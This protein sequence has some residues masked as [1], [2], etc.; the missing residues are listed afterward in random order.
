MDKFISL[1]DFIDFAR[2]NRKYPDSTANNLKSA[3]KI[4]QKELNAEELKSIDMVQESIEEIFRSLVI[5]N[6]EKSIISLNS[7]KARLLKVIKDYRKYGKEPGKMQN[8]ST[9][10]KKSTGVLIKEDKTDKKKISLSNFINDSVENLHKI[11]LSLTSG[12]AQ[13]TVPK[14]IKPSEIKTIK[15]I[16]DSLSTQE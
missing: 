7:Y 6:K 10:E 11:D 12:R 3:L 2:A 8:W 13:I 4:F 15:N 14:N 1:Y 9:K 5:A 16:L